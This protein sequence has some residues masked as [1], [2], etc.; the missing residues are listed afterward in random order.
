M[1]TEYVIRLGG[2]AAIT[3]GLS[4]PRPPL[5]LTPKLALRAASV[6]SSSGVAFGVAL[7]DAGVYTRTRATSRAATR[8]VMGVAEIVLSVRDLPRMRHFYQEVLG[9]PLLSEA[10]HEHGRNRNRVVSPRSLS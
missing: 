1:N 3:A 9:F 4:E 10:C 5:C 6:P 2:S 7:M 8:A